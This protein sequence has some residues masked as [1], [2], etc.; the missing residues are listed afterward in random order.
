VVGVLVLAGLV[1]A[2]NPVERFDRFKEPPAR[3]VLPV[4]THFT[5]DNGSG[6]YQ[7]WDAAVDAFGHEPLRG[8]G[9]GQYGTWWNRHGSIY[10]NVLD[11]H[12]L[13]FETAAELGA[14]GLAIVLLFLAI[15]IRSGWRSRDG[16]QG[17]EAVGLLAL[18]ATGLLSAAIDW[19]WELP[20][21][22]GPIVV[23]TALL[24]SGAAD[25][26]APVASMTARRASALAL[27]TI[28]IAWVALL[29]SG[30]LLLTRVKIDNSHSAAGSGDLAAAADDAEDAIA[31]AP[32][33]SEPRLQLGLVQELQGDLPAAQQSLTEAASRAP[34][35][36]HVWFILSRVEREAGHPEAARSDLERAL[37]E[38]P[39][40][41]FLLRA[42]DRTAE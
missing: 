16:P 20:A 26:R 6:R 31:I 27:A 2:E 14:V 12:S 32:W 5:S 17:A 1:L 28:A 8:I 4:G 3:A 10:Y 13:L 39:R 30:D 37:R 18:L 40:S 15:P 33:S 24:T 7:F 11:A 25:A 41:P 21:V 9:A 36:W 34:H 22:F 35:D 38:N 23:A 19:M 42:V 29:C